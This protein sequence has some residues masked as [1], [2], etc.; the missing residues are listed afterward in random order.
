MAKLLRGRFASLDTSAAA[1]GG[2]YEEDGEE[3]AA[4]RQAQ[5]CRFAVQLA[6]VTRG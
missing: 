6:R 1:K 3:Q 2:S 4:M 5:R